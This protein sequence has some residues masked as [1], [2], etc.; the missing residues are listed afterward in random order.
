MLKCKNISKVTLARTYISRYY[1]VDYKHGNMVSE[2][3]GGGGGVGMKGTD[4]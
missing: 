1:S 2:E 4:E 3:C